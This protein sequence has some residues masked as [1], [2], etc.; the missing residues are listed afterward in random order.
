MLGNCAHRYSGACWIPDQFRLRQSEHPA[1][2]V[3]HRS[4]AQVSWPL[5]DSTVAGNSSMSLVSFCLRVGQRTRIGRSSDHSSPCAKAELP[6][7]QG[8]HHDCTRALAQH[9]MSS[10]VLCRGMME[11]AFCGEPWLAASGDPFDSSTSGF[12]P[13]SS[14]GRPGAIPLVVE[15]WAH[16]EKRPSWGYSC[17]R[18]GRLIV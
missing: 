14:I 11:G 15:E 3:E 6:P 16:E 17:G 18:A 9:C 5:M 12:E 1:R 4:P 2:G 7:R 8:Q 10:A 13:C